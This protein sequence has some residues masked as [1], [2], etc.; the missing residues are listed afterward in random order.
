MATD[1][2]VAQ[3]RIGEAPYIWGENKTQMSKCLITQC[4]VSSVRAPGAENVGHRY[5]DGIDPSDDQLAEAIR[6]LPRSTSTPE[7]CHE[8]VCQTVASHLLAEA[9]HFDEDVVMAALPGFC[10]RELGRLLAQHGHKPLVCAKVLRSNFYRL[11][12]WRQQDLWRREKNRRVAEE[13]FTVTRVHEAYEGCRELATSVVLSK[14]AVIDPEVVRLLPEPEEVQ[15][16]D[17]LHSKL[18]AALRCSKAT[19]RRRLLALGRRL[20]CLMRQDDGC[21]MKESSTSHLPAGTGAC[22]GRIIRWVLAAA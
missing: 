3:P 11:L 16:M 14:A 5:L 10:A 18:A 9:R 13:N 7:G 20:C 8:A 22:S 4:L 2:G 6:R 17:D 19:A 21:F 15:S 1:R 12:R